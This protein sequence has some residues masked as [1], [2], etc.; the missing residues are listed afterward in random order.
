[1]SAS[2]EQEALE[3]TQVEMDIEEEEVVDEMKVDFDA[4]NELASSSSAS[5]VKL[6]SEYQR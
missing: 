2:A 5:M 4:L 1:M 3:D 6:S